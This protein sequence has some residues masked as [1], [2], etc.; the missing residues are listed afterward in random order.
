MFYRQIV[1]STYLGAGKCVALI[2]GILYDSIITSCGNMMFVGHEASE[3]VRHGFELPVTNVF[4]YTLP[5]HSTLSDLGV[6]MPEIHVLLM[7]YVLNYTRYDYAMLSKMV[8]CPL[9]IFQG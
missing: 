1:H 5:S 4:E 6:A 9:R 7:L 8:I 2:L 3:G